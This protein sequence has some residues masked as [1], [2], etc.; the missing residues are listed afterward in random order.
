MTICLD[1]KFA[2]WDRTQS[3]R[4]HPN[5]EGKCLW[6]KVVVMPASVPIYNQNAVNRIT[7]SLFAGYIERGGRGLS[8]CPTYVRQQ[9]PTAQGG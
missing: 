4:L 2:Q 9:K 5:G 6:T 3:G 8:K 1:C 7:N